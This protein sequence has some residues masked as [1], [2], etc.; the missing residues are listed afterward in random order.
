MCALARLSLVVSSFSRARLRRKGD[1]SLTVVRVP[2]PEGR[3][4]FRCKSGA[5]DQR[6]AQLRRRVRS[7][8]R[9]G[10]GIHLAHRGWPGDILPQSGY[11]LPVGSGSSRRPFEF[12]SAGY[13]NSA[14]VSFLVNPLHGQGQPEGARGPACR[15]TSRQRQK[16]LFGCPGR[17]PRP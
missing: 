4:C 6:R 16:I 9:G 3:A 14:G 12:Q 10:R 13:V 8:L 1:H 2:T 7:R 17:P 11:C 15:L 5:I